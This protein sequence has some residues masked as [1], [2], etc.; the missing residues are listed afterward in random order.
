M[1]QPLET[2]RDSTVRMVAGFT[3]G[4]KVSSQS[5]PTVCDFPL[6]TKRALYLS[7]VPSDLNLWRKSHMHLIT[8]LS[9]GIGTKSHVSFSCKA[10]YSACMALSQFG[11]VKAWL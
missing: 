4:L 2:A 1:G 10:E 6:T 7:N 8:G 3:T 5:M 11:S 9:T